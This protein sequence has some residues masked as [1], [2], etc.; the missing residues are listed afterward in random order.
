[1]GPTLRA[2]LT[3]YVES[4]A[5]PGVRVALEDFRLVRLRV[6]ARVRVDA[7]AFDRTAVQ[8]SAQQALIDGFSL[9]R[10]ALAQPA[11]ISEVIALLERV[12]GVETATVQ[13][14]TIPAWSEIRRTART[15]GSPSA[16][17]P[18]DDQVIAVRADTAGADMAVAVETI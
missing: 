11:Y 14:F 12:E 9:E 6:E 4:R 2:D 16:F 15:G 3:T 5:L 8:A 7:E 1:M 10:R 17:F 18:F 13:S